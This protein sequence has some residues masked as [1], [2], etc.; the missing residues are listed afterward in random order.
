MPQVHIFLLKC[1]SKMTP[2]LLQNLDSDS[3]EDIP[4]TFIQQENN[5]AKD[6]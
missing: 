6:E 4:S 1:T 5:T 3:T 2:D